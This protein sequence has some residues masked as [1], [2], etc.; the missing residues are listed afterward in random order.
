MSAL[1]LSDSQP[2]S[3]QLTDSEYPERVGIVYYVDF[4]LGN[5]ANLGITEAL[6]WKTI[7]KI[8]AETFY[9]GD[10]ILF[11]R[12]ETWAGICLIVPHDGL[13]FG[14]YGVGA[15]P[16]LDGQDA[17]NCIFM[18]GKRDI[19]IEYIE[20]TQGLDSCIQVYT[21]DR[22]D[23]YECD[24]HDAGNDNI[25]FISDCND[26]T[27]T[28][29]SSYN[30]YQRMPTTLVSCIEIADG[31]D[32]FVIDDVECY[33]SA[34]VGITVHNHVGT[35]IPTNVVIKN[36]TFRNNT[37]NGINVMAQ[38]T[39]TDPVITIDNCLCYENAVG[40]RVYK[41]LASVYYPSGVLIKNSKFYTNTTYGFY[42]EANGLTM[43]HCLTWGIAQQNRIYNAKNI[44]LYNNTIWHAPAGVTFALY[45]LGDVC[46]N[47]TLKNNIFHADTT[48]GYIIGFAADTVTGAD[49]DYNLYY[50]GNVF[51]A[52]WMWDAV[53]Y[54]YANWKTNSGMD[55]NSPVSNIVD[56][57]FT[58]EA[59]MDLT[60]QAGS[61]AID[62]G[63]VIPGITDGYLG[64][65][66][67]CGMYERE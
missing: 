3:L 43:H 10:S 14:A 20:M 57:A 51:S 34:A 16:I 8:N 30:P 29:G 50:F 26:C 32:G 6:P 62:I 65:A 22:V 13:S 24:C 61:P 33:G 47:I 25:V 59:I 1:L 52:R 45:C 7:T 11:K 41:S 27:V 12:G 48:N 36:S 67:D 17:V 35:E 39:T 4:T 38:D 21:S 18:N 42:F 58:N 15:K 54:T 60:L 5:D 63:V 19:Y 28:G 44:N 64:T 2:N 66:P 37:T 53:G 46:E 56:P 40:I 23:V 49:V 9:E 31:G 55:A